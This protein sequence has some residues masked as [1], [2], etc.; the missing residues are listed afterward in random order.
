MSENAAEM[1]KIDAVKRTGDF[2]ER[3]GK[4]G[5]RKKKIIKRPHYQSAGKPKEW[6]M[7]KRQFAK[8][9]EG[10]LIDEALRPKGEEPLSVTEELDRRI[11]RGEF[12]KRGIMDA[13][14]EWEAVDYWQIDYDDDDEQRFANP[15]AEA[16]Y[17]QY[18]E[19]QVKERRVDMQFERTDREMRRPEKARKG[20]GR[21]RHIRG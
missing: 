3:Q 14:D 17:Q 21:F 11:S 19:E 7:E 1:E 4:E 16:A 13:T 12:V 10:I 5:G 20:Q 18:L 2:I 6:N 9:G 8:K 15:E